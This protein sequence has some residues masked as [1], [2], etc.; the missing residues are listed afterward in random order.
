MFAIP[1]DFVYLS[2]YDPSILQDIRYAGYHN[3][4][5]RPIAGYETNECILTKAAAR[6]LSN[7]QKELLKSGYSLKVYDGY[8]PKMAVNDFIQ[9]SRDPSQQQMKSEFYPNVDK[10]DFFKL[11][12]VAARSGH[13]RGSTVDVTIVPIPTLSQTTYHQGQRL[14]AC[15][16][17]YSQRFKD[18]SIDMGTGFDCMDAKSHPLNKTGI[19]LTAYQNRMLLRHVMEEHGFMPYSKEWWHFTLKNEP[20]PNTYFNFPIKPPYS[21]FK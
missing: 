4:V 2:Q 3:F 21:K 10:K 18:N 20:Y 5:G 19:P 6:A 7:V 9:W 13:S 17:P 16:A 1:S 11:G 8:R 15:Y 14:I 12:Y